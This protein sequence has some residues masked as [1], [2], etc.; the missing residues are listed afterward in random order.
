MQQEA[1]NQIPAK[2]LWIGM[3]PQKGMLEGWFLDLLPTVSGFVVPSRD[4]PQLT[5]DQLRFKNPRS[6]YRTATYKL[7]YLFGGGTIIF[8]FEC[9]GSQA[10]HHVAHCQPGEALGNL[11]QNVETLGRRRCENRGLQQSG[12]QVENVWRWVEDGIPGC[13]GC[14]ICT[15]RCSVKVI[16]KKMM[17]FDE[18]PWE[19]MRRPYFHI[20]PTIS[21]GGRWSLKLLHLL[22]FIPGKL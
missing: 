20:S 10:S 18:N 13:G 21:I 5:L 8:W 2:H 15:L 4:L 9:A 7:P 17:H 22:A 11:K 16:T 19:N 12:R 3:H 6:V 14:T 1:S